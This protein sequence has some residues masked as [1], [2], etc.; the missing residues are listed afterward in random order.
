MAFEYKTTIHTME[1]R[2]HTTDNAKRFYELCNDRPYLHDVKPLGNGSY[3]MIVNPHKYNGVDD[4][5]RYRLRYI[6]LSEHKRI[7]DQIKQ[8]LH[9]D[10]LKVSRL[11]ICA[12]P[13]IDYPYSEKV[14]RLMVLLLGNEIGAKNRYLS[15]DPLTL[16][17][18][19]IRVEALTG[20]NRKTYNGLLQVE[21]YNRGLLDQSDYDSTVINRLEFRAG[22]TEAGENY[23]LE[24]ITER[25][26]ARLEALSDPLTLSEK[27]MAIE[28]TLNQALWQKWQQL[29]TQSRSTPTGKAF[30]D[31]IFYN[32]SSIY[33]VRQMMALFRLYGDTDQKAQE[34]NKNIRRLGRKTFRGQLLTDKQFAGE[35]NS[36]IQ[37]VEAFSQV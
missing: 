26:I 16:E 28:R 13:Q 35:V 22:G 17:T 1:I 3:S 23:S 29:V 21:N 14:L 18:K 11:D 4:R 12:D 5:G 27:V 37:S 30:N 15:I 7:L 34:R 36:L 10:S 20:Y 2:M 32:L 25:W 6:P 9:T 8:E 31:F 19:T 24:Q 33:T